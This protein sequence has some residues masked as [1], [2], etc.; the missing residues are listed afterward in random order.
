MVKKRGPSAY[1]DEFRRAAVELVTT[2]KGEIAEIARQLGVHPETL[3]IWVRMAARVQAGEIG[4]AH[5]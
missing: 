3:R 1:T 5:V 2:G 4:R